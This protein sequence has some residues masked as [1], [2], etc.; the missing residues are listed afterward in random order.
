MILEGF[1][2]ELG[3]DVDHDINFSRTPERV[4]RM[5]HEVLSGA[6]NTH[7]KLKEIL[8]KVFPESYSDEIVVLGVKAVG[9]C[10]GPH[11]RIRCVDTARPA[12]SVKEGDQVYSVTPEGRL[13][14][15]TVKKIHRTYLESALQM[16]LEEGYPLQVST[17][18]LIQTPEGWK[19]AGDLHEG[20]QVNVVNRRLIHR[21]KMG[22]EKK[23]VGCVSTQKVRKIFS[24]P[25]ERGRRYFDFT[26]EPYGNYLAN[27]IV[28]HNCPHHLMVVRY[29]VD[30][31]YQ[32]DGYVLGASKLIRLVKT[33]ASRPVLQERFTREIVQFLDEHLKCKGAMARVRGVHSCMRDRG[34][35]TDSAL[36]TFASSG[37]LKDKF[38]KFD[39]RV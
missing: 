39:Y 38:S 16:Y 3:I 5:Y 18:H 7:E 15:S 19:K 24:V 6:K 30:V 10:L 21:I 4:Y 9:M 25:F 23:D 34:V 2:D 11:V 26:C 29:N 28:V 1:Q 33:L 20:D 35:H 14:V 12:T 8:E 36:V 17:D 37:T 31:A 13:G 32:P 22:L 27:D